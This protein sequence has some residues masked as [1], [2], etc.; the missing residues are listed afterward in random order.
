MPAGGEWGLWSQTSGTGE[1]GPSSPRGRGFTSSGLVFG[2]AA[3]EDSQ[4]LLQLMVLDMLLGL[5]LFALLKV[6]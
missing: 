4:Y 3:G 6:C 5:G 1:P 2:K